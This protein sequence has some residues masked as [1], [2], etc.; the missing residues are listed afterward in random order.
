[1]L[2]VFSSSMDDLEPDTR[3]TAAAVDSRKNQGVNNASFIANILSKA[4]H[5]NRVFRTGHELCPGRRACEWRTGDF[6]RHGH[7]AML[8][9][10]LEQLSEEQAEDQEEESKERS[11][12]KI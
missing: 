7:A 5:N 6:A 4:T 11:H 1:S 12:P 8:R 10:R 3:S 2:N 9:I